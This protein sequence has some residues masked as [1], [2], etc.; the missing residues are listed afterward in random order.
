MAGTT[1]LQR[2]WAV[3]A[4]TPA[5]EPTPTTAAPVGRRHRS[6]R[7][8]PP[9]VEAA[10]PKRMGSFADIETMW[11]WMN[12]VRIPS[13]TPVD[14]NIYI[15]E[16]GIQPT[17]EDPANA[18]GGRWLVSLRGDDADDA[19]MTLYLMLVGETLDPDTQICGIIA[20][21]R[22]NYIRLSIWT[23]DRN[24]SEANLAIGRRAKQE[25]QLPALEYQDHKAGFEKFRHK[26]E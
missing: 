9:K 10:A 1:P 23:R 26:L 4:D 22:R 7:P 12:N 24:H 5:S 3:W 18:M 25:L 6:E 19:W 20:A 21:H 15:F 8:A 11:R 16:D 14:S 13:K 2:T 17:W